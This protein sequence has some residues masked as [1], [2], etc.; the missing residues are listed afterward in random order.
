MVIF[1]GFCSRDFGLGFRVG[2][3]VE[4]PGECD[5]HNA[6]HDTAIEAN[7][8][9]S[10]TYRRRLRRP[11]H[12]LPDLAISPALKVVGTVTP[13]WDSVSG[14]AFDAVGTYQADGNAA[15]STLLADATTPPAA[16]ICRE[17]R[18]PMV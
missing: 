18:E 8:G 7:R 13:P 15:P 10:I 14:I 5:I 16:T 1:G 6:H 2:G 3:S 4:I 11:V 12:R 9:R 17:Y